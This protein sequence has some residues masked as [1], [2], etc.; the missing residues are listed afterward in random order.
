MVNAIEIINVVKDI[1]HKRIIN[2]FS[3]TINKGEIFGLLGPNGAGKTTLIKL[4]VGLIFPTKGDILING[5]SVNKDFKKAIVEVGALVE[6]PALYPNLSGYK[7]LQIFANMYKGIS[8]KDIDEIVDKLA[9]KDF[10][11][12]KTN[13]YSLGM[14]QR[15]GIAIAL[16]NKP[17]ILIL[18]EPTNGLDPQG[19]LELRSNLKKLSEKD[20]MCVIVSSHMLSEMELTCDRFAIIN[21]GNLINVTDEI[22]VDN[23]AKENYYIEIDNNSKSLE[24]LKAK[25]ECSLE[26]NIL[27]VNIERDNIPNIVNL[28]VANNIKI[29][30]IHKEHTSLEKYYFESIGENN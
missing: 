13:Q 22:S 30:S 10:I 11:K 12:K 21:K 4:I 7:N 14:K 23:K 17:S 24:L 6:N 9:M 18:D 8:K 27:N 16:L 20:G 15:L 3:V 29:Y 5:N 19:I 28:L 26:N 1:N 25:Y 2:D